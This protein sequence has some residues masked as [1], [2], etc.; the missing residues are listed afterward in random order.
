M[1]KVFAVKVPSRSSTHAGAP[2]RG[3]AGGPR[4]LVWDLRH[5]CLLMVM[6]HARSAP[7]GVLAEGLDQVWQ[8]QLLEHDR[9]TGVA[10]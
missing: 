10:G 7:V 5:I 2:D 1:S 6:A 8:A 9:V 4:H 3:A